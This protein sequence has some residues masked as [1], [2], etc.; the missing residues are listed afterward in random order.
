MNQSILFPDI[1][2]W[3]E[4]KEAVIF[5]AQCA[6]ALIECTIT[7]D[8]LESLAQCSLEDGHAV[9]DAFSKL[10]F[11]IEEQAQEMIEDERYNDLDQIEIK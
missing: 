8:Y 3:D 10:R 1:Q 7:K 5:P 9:I 11:D 6:G 4:A 2:D